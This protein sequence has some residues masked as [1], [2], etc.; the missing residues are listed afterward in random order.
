M[1]LFCVCVCVCVPEECVLLVF[2][3]SLLDVCV[4]SPCISVRFVYM[5]FVRICSFDVHLQVVNAHMCSLRVYLFAL[6]I[7]FL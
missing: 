4:F 6:C 1:H 3:P 7:C 2:T 5:F